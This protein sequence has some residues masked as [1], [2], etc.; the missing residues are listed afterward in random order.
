MKDNIKKADTVYSQLSTI[1]R[2]VNEK[3]DRRDLKILLNKL[4]ESASE[5]DSKLIEVFSNL[6]SK[7]PNFERLQTIG[8]LEL[9]TNYLDPIFPLFSTTLL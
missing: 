9:T 3:T 4:Y 7:L 1:L 6:L 5:D 8:E 2:G